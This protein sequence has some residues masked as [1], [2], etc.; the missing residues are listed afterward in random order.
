MRNLSAITE[1]QDIIT[2]EYLEGYAVPLTRKV[3]NK[4]LSS[5]ITL[6][7]SDVGAAASSHTHVP[8]AIAKGNDY[9][10]GSLNPIA[11]MQVGSASS[12]KS[13]G[14]PAEAITIEYSRDGGSTWTSY[15]ATDTQKKGL[16]AETRGTSFYIGK[17]TT[18]ELNSTDCQLRVTIEPTDRYVSFDSIY[19]WLSTSGNTIKVDLENSTIG[20]KDTFVTVFTN[21]A[22]S[23]WS[24][25]NIRYFSQKTFGGSA[26]QTT[27][28]YKWRVTFK[29]SAIYTGAAGQIIDIRFFGLN[30]W[31]TPNNFVGKNHLYSWD[32]DLNAIF[33]K[34]ISGRNILP[35]A[36]K[37]YDLGSTGAYWDDLYIVKINGVTVGDSPKFTDTVTRV[38]GDAESSYRS[39]DVNLTPANIG[40]SAVGHSHVKTDITDFAHSHVKADI[41]D[42]THTHVKADITDFAHNHALSEI[43]GADDLR[44]IEALSGTSGFLKKTAANTWSLDTNT[45]SLSTHTHTSFANKVTFPATGNYALSD[46]TYDYMLPAASGTLALLSDIP[47]YS[48]TK[49]TNTLANTTKAYLTG[50]T[51]AS[52]NTGTQVFDDGVYVTTTA[53]QLRAKTFSVEEK[54]TV[55]YDSTTDCINFV[56]A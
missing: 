29:Q 34:N 51:S 45:Y 4:A 39:G 13:F 55:Q 42:F 1:N 53:G 5:D 2:K 56:F 23:G 43:T 36:D 8:S 33:P 20:A 24:G 3:N 12:N 28:A 6:S 30:V 19:V 32:V 22:M 40:A 25:N 16:F 54:A 41:T 26:S 48:D 21:Q 17:A 31:S 52:T 38:K 46:G 11:Q 9:A 47:S 10:S 37:T 35:I 15:G 44:A 49:V 7:A 18:A 27:N 14:L 50:T